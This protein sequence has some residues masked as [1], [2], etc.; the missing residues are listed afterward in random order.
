MSNYGKKTVI[1][2]ADVSNY[3]KKTD[4][5]DAEQAEIEVMMEGPFQ[6]IRADLKPTAPQKE[7]FWA[8]IFN[9]WFAGMFPFPPRPPERILAKFA[10]VIGTWG[11]D[12]DDSPQTPAGNVEAGSSS[13]KPTGMK[14]KADE[15]SGFPQVGSGRNA[16]TQRRKGSAALILP[17][18]AKY[19]GSLTWLASDSLGKSAPLKYIKWSNADET[20]PNDR[21]HFTTEQQISGMAR[22]DDSQIAWVNEWNN[23]LALYL[24]RC[25]IHTMEFPDGPTDF[26]VF[27]TAD[28]KSFELFGTEFDKLAAAKRDATVNASLAPHFR[29]IFP[30]YL[31]LQ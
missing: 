28:Y 4:L 29:P 3:T 10:T 12:I 15:M 21:G 9:G 6:V 17:A 18:R 2:I 5:T 20:D 30:T 11:E 22:Y 19:L 31:A 27:S 16:P 7:T 23:S 13:S 8:A 1:T 14:R 24:I 25:R 26:A